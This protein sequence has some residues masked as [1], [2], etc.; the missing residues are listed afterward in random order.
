MQPTFLRRLARR[1][2]RGRVRP[3]S[4]CETRA[5]E[6]AKREQRVKASETFYCVHQIGKV[7]SRTVYTTLRQGLSAAAVFH[8]H[9]LSSEGLEW[10]EKFVEDH[11]DEQIRPGHLWDGLFVADSLRDQSQSRRWRFVTL[12]RDPLARAIS[13]FF[14]ELDVHARYPFAERM[15]A[16]GETGVSDELSELLLRRL[17][18]ELDWEQAYSWFDREMRGPTGIDV[19]AGEMDPAAPSWEWRGDQVDLLL[20]KTEC[21]SEGG[22]TA[23]RAFTQ[24]PGLSLKARNTG[25]AKYYAE[26]YRQVLGTLHIGE[27]LLERC[28]GSRQVKSFYSLEELDRFRFRWA[29]TRG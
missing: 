20:L 22:L 2:R 23:L 19:F 13:E 4:F 25:S 8:T 7:G 28:Y 5:A 10:L 6:L 11:W 29:S 15:K 27:K 21:L 24:A 3:S 18:D 12:V 14:E 1:L 9:F 26:V 17:D 16:V